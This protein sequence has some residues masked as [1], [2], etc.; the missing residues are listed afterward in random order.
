MFYLTNSSH[1]DNICN[2]LKEGVIKPGGGK[3][4]ITTNSK[5]SKYLY[6]ELVFPENKRSQFGEAIYYDISIMEDYDFWYNMDWTY[7]ETDKDLG[8]KVPK[9]I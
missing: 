7:I 4:I 9:K 3:G 1:I 8:K 2:I 6:F 5:K